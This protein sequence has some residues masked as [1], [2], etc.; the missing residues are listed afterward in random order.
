MKRKIRNLVRKI[1]PFVLVGIIT[2]SAVM[3]SYNECR[4]VKAVAVVDDVVLVTALLAMCGVAWIGTEYTWNNGDWGTDGS[5]ALDWGNG[6]DDTWEK[7]WDK[8][9]KEQGQILGYLDENGYIT[10][11]DGSGSDP[12][13]DNNKFP[14]WQELKQ[15][16]AE[17]SG[18]IASVLTALT[19]FVALFSYDAL[20]QSGANLADKIVSDG[21]NVDV[22]YISKNTVGYIKYKEGSYDG[23]IKNIDSAIFDSNL[24]TCYMVSNGILYLYSIYVTD[25]NAD[26]SLRS[27]V[28]KICFGNGSYL[29]TAHSFGGYIDSREGVSV[30]TVSYGIYQCRPTKVVDYKFYCP[31]FETDA[32]CVK[33]LQDTVKAKNKYDSRDYLNVDNIGMSSNLKT[34]LKNTD[35]LPQLPLNTDTGY[36][37]LPSSSELSQYLQALKNTSTSAEKDSLIDGFIDKITNP[38]LNPEPEP[39]PEP[40]PE[41]EPEPEPKPS[42]D[43]ADLLADL[44]HLFPFCVP[45][46]LVDCFKLF[47][48]EPVT[49]RVEFPIHFGIV[50][51]DYTFVIDLEDFNGV[52]KVCRLMFLIGFIVSLV[53]ATRQLIR[54]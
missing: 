35:D 12:D 47:N 10:G 52:A 34:A 20:K 25:R 23:T 44:K 29:G 7:Q 32:E 5:S 6:F 14:S 16:L 40:K 48:A 11:G 43:N 30:G 36:L 17:N 41:P 50:E 33:Y 51:K 28:H 27:P 4:D 31:K 19:P 26:G 13:D 2:S 54:G 22:S 18:N 24:P 53:Y 39:K 45:F 1:L 3:L 21:F 49:P 42:E 46:D 15:K 37:R 9:V 8:D 38:D